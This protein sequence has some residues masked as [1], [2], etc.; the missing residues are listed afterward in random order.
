[1][2]TK[3]KVS[4]QLISLR[5]QIDQLDAELV[6]LLNRRAELVTQVRDAKRE[7]NIP[8][9]SAK[10]EREILDRATKLASKGVFPSASVQR[11]FTEIVSATRSLIGDLTVAYLGE[12]FSSAHEAARRQFGEA[13]T[14]LNVD[15]IDQLIALIREARIDYGVIPAGK[16][17]ADKLEVIAKIDGVG[18]E[19]F[20]VVGKMAA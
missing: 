13:V 10:R 11:I 20:C 9:Y 8:V 19:V 6:D 15:S 16:L 14:F 2:P 1:M 4:A 18:E 12:E 3:E 7:D 5:E 17:G